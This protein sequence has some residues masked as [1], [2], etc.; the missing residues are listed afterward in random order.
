MFLKPY[1]QII[2][3]NDNDIHDQVY[4]AGLRSFYHY[5]EHQIVIYFENG[6]FQKQSRPGLLNTQFT[7]CRNYNR[8][9]RRSFLAK[10][11]ELL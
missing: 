6:E 7:Y 10:K 11:I 8:Q 9:I 5:L 2:K 1:A 4:F 3:G